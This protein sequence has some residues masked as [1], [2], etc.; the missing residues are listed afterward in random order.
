MIAL[1]K[2][3]RE[4]VEELKK[5]ATTPEELSERYGHTSRKI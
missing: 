1:R 4:I 5:V 2:R 3:Y